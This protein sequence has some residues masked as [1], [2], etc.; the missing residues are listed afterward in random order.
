[1]ERIKTPFIDSRQIK[2]GKKEQKRRK[3]KNSVLIF[4]LV[5]LTAAVLIMAAMYFFFPIKNVII[6]GNRYLSEEYIRKT[7]GIS[8]GQRYFFRLRGKTARSAE[9]DP[10]FR[11]VTIKRS[12]N[13]SYVINIEENTIVG[14]QITGSNTDVTS[15]LI[16]ADGQII[17]FS[18]EYMKN[19]ALTP[20]FI[21][22]SDENCQKIALQLG[23]LDFD[24]LSRISEISVV[25]FTYDENMIKLTMEDGYRVYS[26]INGL[27]YMKDYFDIVINKSNSSGSCI[28]IMEEYSSA[29]ILECGEIEENYIKHAE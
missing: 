15:T 4:S 10:L 14:Y 8:D 26:S 7:V 25:S 28:L 18:A 6:T 11:K 2:A 5:L 1:M 3:L 20:L 21:N 9:N 23:K 24:I 12:E 16:L 29:A 17:P 19:I 13:L 22:I 27:G